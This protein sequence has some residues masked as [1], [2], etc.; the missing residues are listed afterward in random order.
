VRRYPNQG[1]PIPVDYWIVF[2]DTVATYSA[3]GGKPCKFYVINV[4]DSIEVPFVFNNTNNDS[5]VSDQ[6]AVI[7][8]IKYG[9]R[10]RGTWQA[11]FWA[12]A[13]SIV[14]RDSTYL[15][16][17]GFVTVTDTI[18]RIRIAKAPKPGDIFLIRSFKPF[19]KRDVF[20][21]TA[22]RAVINVEQA[23]QQLNSVAVVPNPYV[24]ASEWERKPDLR[25]G[26]G[27]RLLY[28]IHLP[29][30]CTIRIYTLSGELVQTLEHDS[31][32]E[33]GSEAWDLL[34]KDQMEIAYGIYIFHVD[35]PG[36]GQQIGKF[37]VI[38]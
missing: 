5:T 14:T 22:K 13:D 17:N 28:F 6:D 27:E 38:K 36:V 30:Q 35:A 37:A 34:S 21:Y 20:T 12:P 29:K 11:K 24:A 1:I 25:S 18:A 9:G 26:R 10:D 4:T 32:M 2:T 8:L 15:T 33:D 3:N 23:R 19:S 7:P 31:M 16:E